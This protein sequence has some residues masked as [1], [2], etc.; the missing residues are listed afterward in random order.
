[1][2]GTGLINELPLGLVELDASGTVLY[3][4]RDAKDESGG[5]APEMVGRN[6]FTDVAPVATSDEFRSNL[7]AFRLAHAPSHSFTF[8]FR[9][10]D[11]EMPV[12]V[13]LARVREDGRDGEQ[14][15]V[16]VHIKKAAAA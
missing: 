14:S 13:L 16:L 3:Y 11:A 5:Q 1:M 7:S 15:T 4:N 12:R 9:D 10:G 6:F 8:I 2:A